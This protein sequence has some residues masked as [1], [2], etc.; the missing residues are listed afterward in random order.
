M[1]LVVVGVL[2]Q[3]TSMDRLGIR[4]AMATTTTAGRQQN[5]NRRDFARPVNAKKGIADLLSKHTGLRAISAIAA[6]ARL[7]RQRSALSSRH[8]HWPAVSHCDVSRRQV[9]NLWRMHMRCMCGRVVQS[10]G[11]LHYAMVDGMNVRD[12]RVANQPPRWNAAPGQELLIIRRNH[13]TGEVSLDP[14]RSGLI[15]HWCTDPLGGRKPINA[16][17]ETVR[18]LPTF[19]EAYRRRR[20]IVPVD[21]FSSGRRSKGKR[22]SNPMPLP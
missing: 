5:G 21:G 20:C 1:N 8:L 12:S 4:E 15:P 11:P 3:T 13:D 22:R 7:P 17:C 6:R 2:P 14:L 19:R 9:A 18:D 10:S 16:K